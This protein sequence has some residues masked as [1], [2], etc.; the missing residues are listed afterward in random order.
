MNRNELIKNCYNDA[1]NYP[2]LAQKLNNIGVASYTVDTATG[3]ILYRFAEGETILHQENIPI[4][5]IA[6]LFS[7]A[8]TIQAIRD[9]QQGKSDY[10]G[11]ME[12]IAAAGVYFYE[13]TLQ[14]TNRR[15]TY[16]GKNGH[17]AES[18]P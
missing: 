3:S 15:V 7:E 4:R 11:F 1:V 6:P 2:D 10:P 8:L 9:N 5:S 17:Y 18:I 13:A 14:G 16:I 12:A